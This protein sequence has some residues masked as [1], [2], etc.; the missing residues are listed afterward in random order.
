MAKN[1]NSGKSAISRRPANTYRAARLNVIKKE[2]RKVSRFVRKE[3][4]HALKLW[5]GKNAA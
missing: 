2:E 5:E 3:R 4:W 1:W